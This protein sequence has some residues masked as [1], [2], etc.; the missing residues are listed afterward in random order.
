MRL[1][2]R[3]VEVTDGNWLARFNLGTYLLDHGRYVEAEEHLLEGLRLKPDDAEGQNNLGMVRYHRR[4]LT[5]AAEAFMA[6]A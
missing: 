3:A 6:A 4:N 1:F 2:G 5:G